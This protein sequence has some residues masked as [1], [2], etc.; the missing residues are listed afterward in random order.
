MRYL[1]IPLLVLLALMMTS[2]A[3]STTTA[4]GSSLQGQSTALERGYRTGYS[5]GYSA[6]SRDIADHAARDYEN[7]NEYQ[8][9]DR[10]YNEVWGT[11]EDYRNGYQ[12]GFESGYAAGYD[13]RPFDSSIP[14]GL[15]RRGT[16]PATAR[17]SRKRR[18][19]MR[20]KTRPRIKPT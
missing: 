2:W 19:R 13:R 11:V 1:K 15:A 12:Q 5:D 14:T 10:N 17:T 7:K 9:A 18:S 4:Q 16:A 8:H 6:G 3:R 20:I